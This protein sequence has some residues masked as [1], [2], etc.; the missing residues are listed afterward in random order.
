MGRGE[1]LKRLRL[2]V[3]DSTS[4][5]AIGI[6]ATWSS[7][8][9]GQVPETGGLT[10]PTAAPM[11]ATSRGRPRYRDRPICFP[12]FRPN[13]ESRQGCLQSSQYGKRTERRTRTP[14]VSKATVVILALPG[15]QFLAVAVHWTFSPKRMLVG[16]RRLSLFQLLSLQRV[17]AVI[18]PRSHCLRVAE[19][20]STRLSYARAFGCA[21]ALCL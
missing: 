18:V 20:M 11:R 16:P 12:S 17:V 10:T 14:M 13:I 8:T 1:W 19:P 3:R 15:V 5:F 2:Y 21:H 6:A 7:V 4:W 9:Y